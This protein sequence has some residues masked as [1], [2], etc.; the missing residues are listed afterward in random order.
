MAAGYNILNALEAID[1]SV[2]SYQEWLNV[3]MALKKEG[4]HVSDWEGW[5]L[6]DPGRYHMGECEKKWDSFN[7]DGVTGGTIVQYARDQGWAPERGDYNNTESSSLEWN[8]TIG[9]KDNLKIVDRE[10]MEQDEIA[11]FSA[12]DFNPARELTR[13]LE[14]LFDPDD[15]VGYVTESYYSEAQNKYLPTKGYSDRTAGELIRLLNKCG[16]DIGKVVGDYNIT[17]G[18]WIRFNP[19]DGNGVKNENV[20]EYRYALV[21]SDALPIN[22][23]YSLIKALELPVAVLVHS[24]G[25]SLHAIVRIGA[26]TYDDYRKRVDYLYE[27]CKKNGLKLDTQNRNPSRLSRMPGVKRGE[28]YQYIVAENLGHA[29]FEEWKDFV[30]AANDELP[31]PVSLSDVWDNMPPLAPPLIDGILR[32]G[33]KMLLA[34]PSKAGKSYA[35]IELTCA[36]ATGTSWMGWK[37]HQGRVLYVNLELDTP[38]NYGRFRNVAETL[39]L[40][41]EMIKNHVD[42]WNLRGKAEP[43]DVLA[44]K[45]IRRCL[46]RGYKAVI[47]DPIYKVITGDE[48]AADQMS[49]FCNQFDKIASDLGCAV[50]Y[51]HHHSKGAQGGKKSMDRASGSGVFARDP[52][53]LID[54]TQLQL[55][56]KTIDAIEDQAGRDALEPY[57]DK[58]APNWRNNAVRADVGTYMAT[59]NYMRKIGISEALIS[60]ATSKAVEAQEKAMQWTAWRIEG[61]LR[62]FP[63]FK[64]KNIWFRHPVH[65]EDFF[66][67]LKDAEI[68]GSKESMWMDNFQKKKTPEEAKE[69][70]TTGIDTAFEACAVNGKATLITLAEYLGCTA[71]TVR[72]RAKE[73]GGFWVEDGVI[74]RKNEA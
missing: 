57:L 14:L 68:E 25:K 72:N 49:K 61:T 34:G 19:L 17:C 28:N 48:N 63:S 35:L 2:L 47:I 60:V 66:G 62:E 1:P 3:G 16:G 42:V 65:V 32:E 11:S 55:P 20:T 53:A 24:G 13:Y 54:M 69:D 18:A 33:H 36:I 37:C 26:S 23:Q 30:E 8:S 41:Q 39:N 15:K 10:W 51:C 5:S 21:E 67:D 71:K 22:E 74:G 4:Y 73:H 44:P 6:R 31:D 52:D 50:I 70:R 38:S 43:M 56:E 45:L 64:P 12:K 7:S 59:V 9:P 29:S 58:F 40:N 27:V 46:K